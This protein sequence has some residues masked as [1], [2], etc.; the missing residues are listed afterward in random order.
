MY[1]VLLFLIWG[2]C[3]MLVQTVHGENIYTANNPLIRYMGRIDFDQSDHALLSWSGSSIIVTFRGTKIAAVMS[4]ANS[5]VALYVDGV[6]QSELY[7]IRS[8]NDTVRIADN[9][10]DSEHEVI[11]R[12]ASLVDLPLITFYSIVT[13]GELLE[14]PN[15]GKIKLEYF[16]DSV[17][18]GYAAATPDGMGRDDRAY[19]DNTSAYTCLLAELL[20]AEYTNISIGGLAV[21]EGAGSVKLGM[22]KRFDKLYPFNSNKLWDFTKYKPDLCIMALGVN[23]YYISGGISWDEW[24]SRYKQIVLK[25]RAEYGEDTPFLFA[26]APMVSSRSE[27]VLNVKKLVSELKSLGINASHYI[28]SFLSY[29]G[30]LIASEHQRAATEL[31]KFIN[32]NR[33][34]SGLKP[35]VVQPEKAVYIDRNNRKLIIKGSDRMIDSL[36]VY[37]VNGVVIKSANV[38][39]SDVEVD[40]S[41]VQAGI[42]FA[43]INYGNRSETYKLISTY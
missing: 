41:D 25:L 18:E 23:E 20:D 14:Q 13:D 27:P 7:Q 2:V 39:K 1:R 33:L 26:V 9:L 29:N 16:G 43:K 10:T 21:C 40:V 3:T 34:V 28:Y 5:K 11:I 36:D 4:G 17:S 19:D 37:T 38:G 35:E 12:R 42:Y 15:N 8:G 30:H 22:E 31:Y 6:K 24:R 32:E